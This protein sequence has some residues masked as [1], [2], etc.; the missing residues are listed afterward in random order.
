MSNERIEY[1]LFCNFQTNVLSYW[2]FFISKIDIILLLKLG[3]FVQALL[4]SKTFKRTKNTSCSV[5]PSTVGSSRTNACRYMCKS[6]DQK[7]STA[8]KRP[9]SVAPEVNLRNMQETKQGIHPGFKTQDRRHRV[10]KTGIPMAPQKGL[11]SSKNLKERR[12]LC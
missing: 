3:W 6:V 2:K 11:M 8:I 7:G 4:V 10:Y 1:K 9:A 5:A 12:Y